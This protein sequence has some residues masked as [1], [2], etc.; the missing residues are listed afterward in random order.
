[1]NE[2][3][4]QFRVGAMILAAFLCAAILV[5]LFMGQPLLQRSHTVFIKFADAPGVARGT[6]IRRAGIRIGQVREVKFHPED[7]KVIV[8]ADINDDCTLYDNEQC[9][10]SNSLLTGDAVLD[11]VR[12]PESPITNEPLKAKDGVLELPGQTSQDMTASI[13][14]LQGQAR[15]T[16]ATL[17]SASQALRSMLTRVDRLVATNEERINHVVVQVDETMPLFRE[18]LTSSN[19]ILGDPKL[20]ETLE[21][22]PIL[23]KQMQTTVEQVQGTFGSLKKNMQNIEPLTEKLGEVGPGL[24]LE[25]R[26]SMKNL[27]DLSF[28]LNKFSERL[29]D[30]QGSLG[31]LLQDKGELYQHVNHIVQNVDG[32]SSDLKPILNNLGILSDKLARH[33]ATLGVRGAL[34][35][36]TGLKGNPT[37]D[38]TEPPPQARRWP[39]GGSGQWSFGNRQ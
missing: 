3:T 18:T 1:M 33:P 20:R 19:R 12:V 2:R 9:K 30:P 11:V 23:L 15:E 26:T 6:P 25:L 34:E 4:M 10:V 5:S 35:K 14:G 17:T 39:I 16:M 21:E 37:G 22:M 36:D 31:A 29:N 32:L 13:A 38:G 8:T 27:D 24:V 28:N 7:Y